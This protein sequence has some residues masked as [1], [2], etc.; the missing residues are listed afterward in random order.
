VLLDRF[1]VP[2]PGVYR[3]QRERAAEVERL[4]VVW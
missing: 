3:V 2:D 4:G 1:V